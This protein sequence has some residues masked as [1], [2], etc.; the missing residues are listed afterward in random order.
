[1]GKDNSH[2]CWEQTGMYCVPVFQWLH[3]LGQKIR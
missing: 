1:M 3:H 2:S